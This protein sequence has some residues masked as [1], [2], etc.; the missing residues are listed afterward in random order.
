MAIGET[1]TYDQ[2]IV[3]RPEFSKYELDA[4]QL[5]AFR[6][7]IPIISKTFDPASAGEDDDVQTYAWTLY[8]AH[9]ALLTW[10]P[11][12]GLAPA[13]VLGDNSSQNASEGKISVSY[14]RISYSDFLLDPYLSL[15]QYGGELAF[16]IRSNAGPSIRVV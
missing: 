11:R 5:A 2:F 9:I 10:L 13:I 3:H 12:N 1:L 4:T 15:T 6:A 7:W 8:V 14:S 16:L